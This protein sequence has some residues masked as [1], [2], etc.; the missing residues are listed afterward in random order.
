MKHIVNICAD[1]QANQNSLNA[2]ASALVFNNFLH[3]SLSSSSDEEDDLQ[4]WQDQ[5]RKAKEASLSCARQNDGNVDHRLPKKPVSRQQ[6]AAAERKPAHKEILERLH[7]KVVQPVVSKDIVSGSVEIEKSM[8]GRG[9]SA[10][11]DNAGVSLKKTQGVLK[12]EKVQGTKQ[13]WVAKSHIGTDEKPHQEISILDKTVPQKDL[14]QAQEKALSS[15]VKG[16]IKTVNSKVSPSKRDDLSSI[17]NRVK[18]D[19]ISPRNEIKKTSV[20]H[21]QVL[22]EEEKAKRQR[23]QRSL[24]NLK[25]QVSS[26]GYHPAAPL[27]PVLFHEVSRREQGD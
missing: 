25:P 10:K 6:N 20:K 14:S 9:T 5:R 2:L 12:G 18:K 1:I 21:K 4:H 13:A 23:L 19:L 7:E 16:E 8:V 26:H 22:T 17:D 15:P 11:L 3:F 24:Q 27:T